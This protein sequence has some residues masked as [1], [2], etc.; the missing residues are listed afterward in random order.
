[1]RRV[2]IFLGGTQ[3]GGSTTLL[4]YLARHRQLSPPLVK[5]PHFFD[6]EQRNWRDPDT[7]AY[8]AL[9]AADDGGRMRYDATPIHGFWPP[10]LQRIHYYNPDARLIFLFRDPFARAWS[11]WC[12]EWARGDETLPFDVA[13]RG[14][15]DRMRATPPL[16]R[17]SRVFSYVERGHYGAQV[18][19]ALTLFPREQ[20]L[21]LKSED[22]GRSHVTT[23]ARIALFLGIA[24][25]PDMPRL[26][27]NARPDVTYPVWPTAADRALMRDELT[28]DSALFARLT[29]LD[30]NDWDGAIACAALEPDAQPARYGG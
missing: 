6:D 24:P 28:D 18:L 3:K 7:A 22:F 21:F 23:L 27:E 25:F 30:I 9:Y 11:H 29:G 20:M 19:R 10:A 26:R 13:I 1:M 4:A 8:D 2:E 5:E 14:G 15:R 17:A 12:M 16:S